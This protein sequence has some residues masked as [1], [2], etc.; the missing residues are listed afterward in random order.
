MKTKSTVYGQF[1][2]N[3]TEGRLGDL[4]TKVHGIQTGPFGSQ[5]HRED[6][7]T[8]GTPILTIEHIGENRII[9]QDL[10]CVSKNDNERLSKYCLAEGDIVFSR[11]GSVDRRSIVR[12]AEAGWLFSGRC[13]RV[14][15]DQAMID[16]VFLSYFFGLPAFRE[17]VRAIAVG[18]TMPSLNTKLLSDLTILYPTLPEQRTIAHILGTLDDKIELNRQTNQ[19]LEEMA[20][21]IYKDWFVDFGPIRAKIDGRE[22]YLPRE[23]W[24]LFPDRLVDSELGE[25]PEGWEAGHFGHFISHRNQRI[26]NKDAIVLSAV[27]S[28]KLVKSTDLFEKRVHSL[29]VSQYLTVEQWDIA[30]NP[31]RINIG[32]VGILKEPILGAVSPVYIVASPQPE[33]RRFA[34]FLLRSSSTKNWINLLASGSVRQSLSF[35][36]FASIPCTIPN[37]EVLKLFDGLWIPLSDLILSMAY[38]SENLSMQRD[39]LLP[40]L[41]AG[42]IRAEGM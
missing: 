42:E 11:V 36:D 16:P 3:L 28:G 15:P 37:R 30:Y 2:D 40:K 26:G 31:S 27:A 21:A 17:H 33:F 34:E 4:C 35:S 1:A 41:I 14:R 5:L 39:T 9:H 7:V 10:P 20:H 22:P 25:I 8:E 19:A 38:E 23:L 12:Q 18:A 24:D 6:Y 13:L 29:D 32:S